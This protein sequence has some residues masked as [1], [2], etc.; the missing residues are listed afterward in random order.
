MNIGS[1]IH[2][3][4]ECV[5]N[6]VFF[7][8]VFVFRYFLRYFVWYQ[9]SPWWPAVLV[10]GGRRLKGGFWSLFYWAH[11]MAEQSGQRGDN[12]TNTAA[13]RG[14]ERDQLSET[15]VRYS[16]RIKTPLS[17]NLT[18]PAAGC[19]TFTATM[20]CNKQQARLKVSWFRYLNMET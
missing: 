14:E 12:A 10:W 7:V 11:L 20:C 16:A 9:A 8:S 5:E 17:H 19:W 4:S 3:I 6:I 2:P 1:F 13:H 18:L 15:K